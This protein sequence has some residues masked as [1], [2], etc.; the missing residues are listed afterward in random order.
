MTLRPLA[1]GLAGGIVWGASVF[2][3]TLWILI[4]GSEGITLGLL[5]KFYLGYSVSWG[6]AFMGLLWGLVD[7][8]VAGFVIAWLYNRFIEY[9]DEIPDDIE[10]EAPID[11]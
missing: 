2:A 8:F 4:I 11:D 9:P 1:L 3:A 6:G 7:G 10:V 5:R